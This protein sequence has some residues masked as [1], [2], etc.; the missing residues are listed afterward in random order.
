MQKE[1]T[2]VLSTIWK[3]GIGLALCIGPTGAGEMWMT[4]GKNYT[5]SVINT[6]TQELKASHNAGL[7]PRA[8]PFR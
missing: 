5:V 4:N 2:V 1:I 7:R 8:I 6:K 3:A